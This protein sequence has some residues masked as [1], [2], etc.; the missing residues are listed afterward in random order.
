MRDSHVSL[1]ANVFFK[2]VYGVDSVRLCWAH[3]TMALLTFAGYFEVLQG[4]LS[5]CVTG[6]TLGI[7]ASVYRLSLFYMFQ[8]AHKVTTQLYLDRNKTSP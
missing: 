8:S 7:P 6:F 4:P 2:P 3:S 1:Q 5:K